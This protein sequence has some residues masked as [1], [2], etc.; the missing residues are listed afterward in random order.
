MS[1]M[2]FESTIPVFERVKKFH[3]LARSQLN[4][5]AD[6]KFKSAFVIVST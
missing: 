5:L 3:A 4:E 1:R 6:T 2:V